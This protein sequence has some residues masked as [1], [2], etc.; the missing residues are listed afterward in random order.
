MK[1]YPL[2]KDQTVTSGIFKITRGG[3]EAKYYA[4][5][6]GIEPGTI[7]KVINP[8]NNKIVYAKVLGEMKG[9]RQNEGLDLR[10]SDTAASALEISETDKFIVKL[11]Y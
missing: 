5:V 7:I 6:D 4:L 8:T 1:A 2:S 3:K 10:I 11:N 9:I